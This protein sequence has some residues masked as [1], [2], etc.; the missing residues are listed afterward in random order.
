MQASRRWKRLAAGVMAA[1]LVLAAC[2]SDDNSSSGDTTAP[3]GTGAATSE[4][5]A[6]SEAPA[7]TEAPASSDTTAGTEATTGTEA[8]GGT[9]ASGEA[10]PLEGQVEVAAGTTLD[11]DSCPDDWSV[12]QGADGDE[13][14]IGMTLPQSGQLASFGP[15]G[16]GMGFYF[17]YLNETDPI[18]GKK[19]VLHHQG[20]RLRGRPCRGERAGD[21]RHRGHLRLRPLHRHPDQRR[22]TRHHR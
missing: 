22:H 11:L 6:A 17:D 10:L 20:R 12:T 19:L 16:E 7:G 13:I 18:D 21:A 15:I 4:A 1:G 8:T 9:G 3:S 5:P 14:R 2:G